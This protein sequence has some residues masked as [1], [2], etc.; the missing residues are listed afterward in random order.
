MDLE[1]A[2]EFLLDNQA[3]AAE[4]LAKHDAQIAALT[5]NVERLTGAV[6]TIIDAVGQLAEAGLQTQRQISEMGAHMDRM[7]A[8]AR[9]RGKALDERID[10]LVSAIGALIP[11]QPPPHP[12][13]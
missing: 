13:T 4:H 6:G 9:Q 10:R 8:E 2:V 1:K 3:K 12:A 5:A 7:D 11:Q